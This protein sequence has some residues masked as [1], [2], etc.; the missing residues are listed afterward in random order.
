MIHTGS[1]RLTHV[2]EEG[3]RQNLSSIRNGLYIPVAQLQRQ[4]V[5]APWKFVDP[6]SQVGVPRGGHSK[7]SLGKV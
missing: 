3:Q 1:V 7:G 5:A 2:E 6:I 4:D